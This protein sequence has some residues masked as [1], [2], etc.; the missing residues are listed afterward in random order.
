MRIDYF[1][2][3]EVRTLRR[4][5]TAPFS[6]GI[7]GRCAGAWFVSTVKIGRFVRHEELLS[8]GFRCTAKGWLS[9]SP[10]D[11]LKIFGLSLPMSGGPCER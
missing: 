10:I 8:S 5:P 9:L 11:R 4:T 3:A 2:A 7:Y 1:S 6:D